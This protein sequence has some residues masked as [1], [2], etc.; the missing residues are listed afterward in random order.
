MIYFKVKQMNKSQQ[1]LSDIVV[2]NK[3]AK[4]IPELKRRE[5]WTEIVDRYLT[6]MIKRY[7]VLKEEILEKGQLIHDKKILPSMRALQFA[8]HA[9]ERNEARLYNCAFLPVDSYHCF[10]ETM[11]LLLSGCGVGYSVQNRHIEKLP[12]IKKALKVRKY[13]VSDS[14]EGWADAVK[15][16]VK[17]YFGLSKTIPSFDF[18]D[19]RAK[20]ER[21]ITSGGKAPGSE[22]LR[23]CLMEIEFILDRKL[24]GD[25]LTSLEI[26][27]IQCHIADAVLAG[28]IRR[29]AMISLFD[30]DDLD[31]INCKSG[32]WWET[33]PQRGRANNSAMLKRGEV[34]REQFND[35]W[36]RIKASGSG[37]PG[38]YWTN[39]LDWGTNPCCEIALRPYQFCNL[40]EINGE[41]ITD[42]NPI[43]FDYL[44]VKRYDYLPWFKQLAEAS[45]FFGTL[46]AGFTNFHYLRS[47]WKETTEE[48]ALIG[49]GITGICSGKWFFKLKENLYFIAD[50][51]KKENERVAD[52][53]GIAIAARTTTVKPSGTTSCVLGTSSGVHAWYSEHY[54]RNMQCKVGDDLYKYFTEHHPNL[55]TI[56]EYD[57]M[58]AVI[59]T[60]QKASNMNMTRNDE[61]AVQM[62]ERVKL[63][64]TQWV[65]KG[66]NR[67]VN[68]NN[69]SATVFIKDKKIETPPFM[70]YNKDTRQDEFDTLYINEWVLVG[71]WMWENRDSY[72][73]L[74][75]LPYDGGTYKNAPF[76]ECTIKTYCELMNYLELNP[77]RL[78]LINEDDDNTEQ[79]DNIACAGGA[80][81]LKF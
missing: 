58:S 47:V 66:H 77:I 6:M 73:G 56:M 38:F 70:H 63:M 48:D 53:I 17:S 61:T 52:I 5:N 43:T 64:N 44:G 46:Q 40:C 62:L 74:S 30:L 72:N 33:N 12:T 57:P 42:V 8:G 45:S 22:P 39:D 19:I 79:V 69:V 9:A 65:H 23:R 24:D 32:S 26:H 11:F 20:G 1:L 71:E 18:G 54:I 68:M 36:K 60:P 55:I 80:C 34:S 35:L 2:Y 67:G 29:A 75:V 81:E 51:V 31:M 7:P 59:A 78:D 13:L 27:D 10:S 76:E 15:A 49:V 25:K 16:L 14:I 4:Y 50:C 21:L 41:A 37:E 28:G 3:Y